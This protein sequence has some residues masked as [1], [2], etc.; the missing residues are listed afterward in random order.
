MFH[1]INF[2]HLGHH[3]HKDLVGFFDENLYK[4]YAHTVNS[5]DDHEKV[6][7]AVAFDICILKI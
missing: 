5:P 1:G 6:K 2:V 4:M 3:I 7:L